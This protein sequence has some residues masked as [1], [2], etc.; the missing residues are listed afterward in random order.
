MKRFVILLLSICSIFIFLRTTIYAGV[1]GD[2]EGPGGIPTE[3]APPPLGDPNPSDVP[4]EPPPVPSLPG[5]PGDP[6]TEAPTQ[7]PSDTPIPASPTPTSTPLPT[8]TCINPT[9][10]FQPTVTPGGIIP[11]NPEGGGGGP[12][13]AAGG[14]PGGPGTYLLCPTS[15][16]V[17]A[18]CQIAC[19]DT[20]PC[21]SS[22]SCIDG[23]CQPPSCPTPGPEGYYPDDP[24]CP[25]RGVGCPCT[26]LLCQD[27]DPNPGRVVVAP[28]VNPDCFKCDRFELDGN[29]V[30]E[31]GNGCGML[32]GDPITL[33]R[34][35]G[36]SC[37][38]YTFTASSTGPPPS[39]CS[40]SQ[41]VCC[42]DCEPPQPVPGEE[43]DCAKCDFKIYVPGPDGQLKETD[44]PCI[45]SEI[46]FSSTGLS[47]Y[48]FDEGSGGLECGN[49]VTHEFQDGGFYDI[50]IICSGGLGAGV[51]CTKR[52]TMACSCMGGQPGGNDPN[53][54]P[55]YKLRDDQFHKYDSIQ[56]PIPVLI[57]AYD[58]D[59]VPSPTPACDTSNPLDIRCFNL[60]QAGVVSAAGDTINLNGAP[61][62][63]RRWQKT[64]Y[65]KSDADL[66]P[67]KF[68]DYVRAR[69]KIVNITEISQLQKNKVNVYTGDLT[70]DRFGQSQ[71]E[72]IIDILEDS[73]RIP[74]VLIVDGNVNI[75]ADFNISDP[76]TSPKSISIITTGTLSVNYAVLE[77]G[78]LYIADRVDLSTGGEK[79]SHWPLK[80]KGNLVSMN[81][82]DPLAERKRTDD[83]SKPSIFLVRDITLDLNLAG[84]MSQ[85][86]YKWEELSP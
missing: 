4:G 58:G 23:I 51:S 12:G 39:S 68:L 83:S 30:G 72:K 34:A 44:C 75:N 36:S 49:P 41:S 53:P 40:C 5:D 32:G 46:T 73:T 27:T 78:G 55:W 3:G 48:D 15:V 37:R 17:C 66:T 62:S 63:Y 29:P 50:T 43:A 18:K 61:V 47:C 77:I 52:I 8:P 54:T 56:N 70:I 86:Y 65:Q 20:K 2:G 1:I 59:D 67:Q 57:T 35:D 79:P 82:I 42:P 85:P 10:L 13:G 11:T 71:G 16:P 31:G 84:L 24:N 38:S 33:D 28:D 45:G 76:G 14:N 26:G 69:K 80:I 81:T 60:N 64:S 22:F 74:Y 7:T 25:C 6:P 19:S 21:C 9:T